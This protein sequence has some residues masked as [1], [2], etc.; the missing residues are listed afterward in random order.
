MQVSKTQL[1]Y[2]S[3]LIVV[4]TRYLF[5][6]FFTLIDWC[7]IIIPL[8]TSKDKKWKLQDE[9]LWRSFSIVLVNFINR[10]FLNSIPMRNM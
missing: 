3:A 9:N 5:N 10:N 8:N 7:Y 4:E 6:F 1:D 2:I